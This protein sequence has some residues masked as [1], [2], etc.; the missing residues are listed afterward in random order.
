MQPNSTKAILAID[1]GTSGPKV[2]LVSTAGEILGSEFEETPLILLPGGGAEQEP[3][4]W[5]GAIVTAA[6]RLLARELIPRSA[7]AGVCCTSQW[8]GTVPLG[9]DGRPTVIVQE[10]GYISDIL[11]DNLAAVLS[12]FD[13]AR[14]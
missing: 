3:D 6:R 11:G 9:R 7:I 13:A 8:S 2:A 10:G 5:W 12:G 14:G 4:A 1:L